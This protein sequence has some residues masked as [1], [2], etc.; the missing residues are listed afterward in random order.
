MSLEFYLCNRRAYNTILNE[1]QYI[2]NIYNEIEEVHEEIC[3]DS[4]DQTFNPSSE[5]NFFIEKEQKINELID[6]CNCKVLELCCHE[7]IDDMIDITP[8]KSEYITYCKICEFT[9]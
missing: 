8:E 9:K 6:I 7:F 3:N 2:I 1:L 5:K 4:L